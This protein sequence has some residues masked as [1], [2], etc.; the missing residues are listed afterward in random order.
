MRTSRWSGPIPV[1]EVVWK[2]VLKFTGGNTNIEFAIRDIKPIILEMYPD[3]KLSN[4]D[5]EITADCVNSPSR[6]QYSVNEDRYWKVGYGTYRLYDPEKD[7]F[8][9]TE[10]QME[11]EGMKHVFISYIRE[12]Q[13]EVDSEVPPFI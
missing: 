13:K 4:V 12:N 2:G 3:F 10:N 7:K 6:H 1:K 11:M 5:A 9:N 8:S